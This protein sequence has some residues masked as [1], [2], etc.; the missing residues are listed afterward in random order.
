MDTREKPTIEGKLV[1]ELASTID[2]GP[3]R[4]GSAVLCVY[5][6]LFGNRSNC[7]IYPPFMA[8][9]V[10]GCAGAGTDCM[11]V[12]PDVFAQHYKALAGKPKISGQ[13]CAHQKL[14]YWNK[15]AFSRP[16]NTP[17][18]QVPQMQAYAPGSKGARQN[19]NYLPGL[20]PGVYQKN[21]SQGFPIR[22][23][24]SLLHGIFLFPAVCIQ[25]SFCRQWDLQQVQAFDIG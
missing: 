12:L 5:D 22:K 13:G 6:C 3:L 23:A 16:K 17:L 24:P 8:A 11:G 19:S 18:L 7:P 20:P 21:I 15:T 4:Y 9:H 14:V 25:N 1:H 2:A 10:I